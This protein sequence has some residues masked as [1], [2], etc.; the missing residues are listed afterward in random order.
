MVSGHFSIA[1][2][3]APIVAL[4]ALRSKISISRQMPTA[5]P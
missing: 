2:P 3:L 4:I 5:P 1:S